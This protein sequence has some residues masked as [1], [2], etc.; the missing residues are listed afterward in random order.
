MASHTAAPTEEVPL[1][2][3]S[4]ARR[5]RFA[6]RARAFI[7]SEHA[8]ADLRDQRLALDTIQIIN[9]ITIRFI[10]HTLPRP[11][12][13]Y[14]IRYICAAC[15]RRSFLIRL[16]FTLPLRKYANRLSG[17]SEGLT[18]KQ[19]QKL[20]LFRMLADEVREITGSMSGDDE[21]VLLEYCEVVVARSEKM[22]EGAR[23]RK[24]GGGFVDLV[25]GGK[26]RRRG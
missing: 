6:T 12:R 9:V 17:G 3:V 10:E 21:E 8:T 15:R 16:I 22:V 18:D 14:R 26:G 7:H 20:R 24:G 11:G 2:E 5:R 1:S 25:E 23:E 13:P 19:R 4:R